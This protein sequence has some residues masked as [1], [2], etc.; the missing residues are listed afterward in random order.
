MTIKV[1]TKSI[2][3][4]QLQKIL[5][6]YNSNK[7]LDEEPLE[8]LD[9]CEGGFK[10]KISYMKNQQCDENNKIKQL[11]WSKGCLVSSKYISFKESE[12]LLLYDALI[13]VLG[14]DNVSFDK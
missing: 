6:Y 1:N 13:H 8:L 12:K 9:R 7:S 2:N 11:R 4:D 14:K 5:D 3:C 10:I